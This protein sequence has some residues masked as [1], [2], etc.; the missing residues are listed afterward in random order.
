MFKIVLVGDS[1]M[2]K[3]CLLLRFIDGTY[4]ENYIKFGIDFKIHTIKFEGKVIKIQMVT[5][6]HTH[7][8]QPQKLTLSQP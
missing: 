8:L 6:T 3:S 5:H 4:S 7:T 2:G 1:H